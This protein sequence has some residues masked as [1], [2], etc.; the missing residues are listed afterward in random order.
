MEIQKV[1]ICIFTAVLMLSA[2]LAFAGAA[3]VIGNVTLE[4]EN[5]WMGDGITISLSCID[6]NG[7]VSVCAYIAG[8]GISLPPMNFAESGGLHI[9]AIDSEYLDRTG[10]YDVNITCA[11]NESGSAEHQESFTVSELTGYFHTVPEESYVNEDM[12]LYFAV[13]RNGIP[14]TSGVSFEV[15]VDG[16]TVPFISPF[17]E[18]G[19]GYYIK[20]QSPQEEGVYTME[21]RASYQGGTMSNTTV[22]NVKEPIDFIIEELSRSLNAGDMITMRFGVMDRG[23][24]VTT[25][26]EDDLEF[27]LNNLDLEI[28]SMSRSDDIYTVSIIPPELSSGSY[29]FEITLSYKG[30]SIEKGETI[31]Y[32][33]PVSGIIAHNDKGVSATLTFQKQSSEISFSTDGTGSYSGTI[34][35][36]LYN[37]RLVTQNGQITFY[38]VNVTEFSDPVKHYYLGSAS[39]PGITVSGVFV[40]ETAFDYSHASI[41]MEY[42]DNDVSGPEEE[43]DVYRCGDWNSGKEEC[44]SEWE[45]VDS[46]VDSIRNVVRVNTTRLSAYVLGIRREIK[47]EYG[48]EKG[49]LQ[50]SEDMKL[51]GVARDEYDNAIDGVEVTAVLQGQGGEYRATTDSQGVFSIEMEAPE[52]EGRYTIRIRAEKEPYV[53]FTDTLEFTTYTK[54][55]LMVSAPDSVKMEA[56]SS[57]NVNFSVVNTGQ[58]ELNN[59]KISISGL[60][61]KM[62]M[63]MEDSI[64]SLKPDEQ[65]KMGVY[66]YVPENKSPES[67]VGILRVS[68]GGTEAEN[69]FALT[70]IEDENNTQVTTQSPPTASVIGQLTEGIE[71]LKGDMLYVS[72]ISVTCI[73]L[74]YFFRRR[75]MERAGSG[76]KWVSNMLTGI[77]QEINRPDVK[78][79]LQKKKRIKRR[80][81]RK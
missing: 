40:Y 62:F 37:I 54:M 76:R 18:S 65:R 13:E 9:L 49:T 39:V 48:L 30:Q 33:I 35:P 52:K 78:L 71:S 68:A 73:F 67:Y 16:Q 4:P 19:K 75:K 24:P 15:R 1:V 74:A 56:G 72:L 58:G 14:L 46:D 28:D 51:N 41:Q 17:Y 63:L 55:G 60:P 44:Y 26:K 61:A 23:V 3:P 47:I 5:P 50:L 12:D 70:I 79:K 77:N 21:V 25:I 38:D 36:G 11:N 81:K 64:S 22:L 59:L 45:V 6:G 27:R 20:L 42:D 31:S 32:N 10:D 29:G 57:R 2:S 7:S 8:P 53:S 80:K 69:T 34:C 43:L 66:F